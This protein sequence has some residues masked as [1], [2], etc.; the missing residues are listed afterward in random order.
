[1]EPVTVL[2]Y[3]V[4]SHYAC[5]I[6]T[7]FYDYIKFQSNFR[8]IQNEITSLRYKVESLGNQLNYC[9]KKIVDKI[10]TNETNG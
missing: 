5:Y 8:S 6:V 1:M 9:T 7:N 2:T 10:K 4:V 3:I